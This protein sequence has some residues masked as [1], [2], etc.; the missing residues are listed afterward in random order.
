MAAGGEL[1]R[2]LVV[3]GTMR[4]VVVVI[5]PPA[6]DDPPGVFQT[7]EQLAIQQFVP[8]TAV[9]ALDVAVFP[10]AALG[11]KQRLHVGSVQ[12]SSHRAGDKLG[13]VI[14]PQ[15][16]RGAADGEQAPQHVE[17]L[18]RL[19][20]QSTSIARLSRVNSSITA[21]SRSLRFASVRSSSRS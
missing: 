2:G 19:I 4:P 15:M 10:R 9:E 20:D 16:L 3:Q 17:H 7:E 14:A 18:R 11:D 12:P 6:I 1:R 8:E 5:K 21:S 13:T